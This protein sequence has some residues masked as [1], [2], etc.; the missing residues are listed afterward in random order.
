MGYVWNR[1]TS[2]HPNYWLRI[3]QGAHRLQEPAR[4]PSG[5]KAQTRD[6]AL[7]ILRSR[8]RQIIDGETGRQ[9]DEGYTV[10]QLCD[11]FLAGYTSTRVR[12]LGSY[13]SDSR[14][15]LA[16]VREA[17]GAKLAS[18]V[19]SA[20]V[21]AL[22]DS[23]LAAGK[24]NQTARHVV[25]RLR[26]VYAWAVRQRLVRQ[27]PTLGVDLPSVPLPSEPLTPERFLTRVEVETLLAWT[28]EHAADW[29]AFIAL[30]V[31]SGMRPPSELHRL[32][33][34]DVDLKRGTVRVRRT[35]V[36]GE[37]ATVQL[38]PVALEALRAWRGCP[39]HVD[40]APVFA[41]PTGRVPDTK[42]CWKHVM[43]CLDG[44]GVR[45]VRVYDLRHSALTLAADGGAGL[46]EIAALAGHKRLDT[47]RRYVHDK[48]KRANAAIGAIK[49]TIPKG[50][51]RPTRGS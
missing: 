49:L 2:K 11:H 50:P 7:A 36:A 14:A 33:W 22:R 3:W 35:K 19:T 28:R 5:L 47:T 45:R 10:A 12:N 34:A 40:N 16:H 38:H 43:R 44:A 23:L 39:W 37:D 15:L 13:R 26:R 30:A 17:L 46:L 18:S 6:Q 41:L 42:T 29:H 20:D 1:G 25:V 8:E 24:S 32:R 48:A 51:R 21:E 9:R 27:N 31:T 4:T